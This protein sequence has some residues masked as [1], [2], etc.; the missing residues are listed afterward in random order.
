MI[1]WRCTD[2]IHSWSRER[3]AEVEAI[4]ARAAAIRE[5]EGR[6]APPR[7]VTIGE[8]RYRCPECWSLSP[9][10]LCRVCG[11]IRCEAEEQA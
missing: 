11:G 3:R 6:P 5:R 10:T 1:G 8:L 4:L 2:E 9:S 7:P